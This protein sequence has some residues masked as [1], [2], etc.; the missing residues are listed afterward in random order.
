MGERHMSFGNI[1]SQVL[2]N[3]VGDSSHTRDR[4]GNAARNLD[5]GGAGMGGIFGQIQDALGRAGIDTSSAGSAA[6][7]FQEKA[8]NFLRKE[9]VG[10]LSGGQIGG[11]GAV[12]GALLG[13][14]LGGA[15]RGGAMAVLGTLALGALKRAQS[16]NAGGD[17][18]QVSVEQEEVEEVTGPETERLTLRAMISAAKADGHIDQQE[19][20]RI[21]GQ[22]D[23]KSVT[24]EEK[25]FVLEELSRPIDLAALAAEVKSPAQAAQVYG[26]SILT[27]D[28]ANAEERQYLSELAAA[29]NLDGATVRELHGLTGAPGS[30]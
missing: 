3:G 20:G 11:I 15:A 22:L 16:K 29:L 27:I 19:M 6:G 23:S 30:A 18:D 4:V 1:I 5:G 7:G 21:A 10:G 24:A 8:G 17:P 28:G 12:A 2:Q 14:G 13:G 9:Q 26:A 25:Q